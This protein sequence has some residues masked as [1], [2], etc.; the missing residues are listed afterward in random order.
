MKV[1]AIVQIED[2]LTSATFPTIIKVARENKVPVFSFVNEQAK[3]GS[4]MVYAP[5]YLRGART[6]AMYAARIMKG[7]K[8]LDIPFGRINKFD[9]IIN[10]SAAKAAGI[11]I[12]ADLLAR[13]NEVLQAGD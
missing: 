2:N 1:D 10:A 5:D 13:A 3:Q 8:P 11:A 6:A 7:E 12:P 9:L 4:V